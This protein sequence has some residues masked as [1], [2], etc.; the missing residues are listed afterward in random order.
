LAAYRLLFFTEWLVVEQLLH[1]SGEVD[2]R[3]RESGRRVGH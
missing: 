3:G 1:H 2:Q